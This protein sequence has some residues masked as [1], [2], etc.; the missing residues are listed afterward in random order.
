MRT[1]DF[2]YLDRN[3]GEIRERMDAARARAG[4]EDEV[5]LIVAAKSGT[6]EEL[7]Y[8]YEHGGVRDFGENRVQQLLE[9]YEQLPKGANIHFIGH[10]QTNKVKYIID[11]VTMIHSLDSER[12][13]AE[14]DKQAKKHGIVMKVL[15]EVNVGEE[16]NKS[17]VL[18]S[19]AEALCE[20]IGKFSNLSL[21]GLMTMAPVCEKKE[22]YL[23]FFEKISRLSVDI[24]SKKRDNK[25]RPI[26]SMGMSG[27][28]EEAIV[29]GATVVRV[30]RKLFEK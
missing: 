25:E 4:R 29:S 2:S 23:K 16:Q 24:W 8:L 9:H 6:A 26:L 17:G 19:E 30:G 21:C 11:K 20:A 3:L 13:A 22:D 7:N 5:G 14:I 10:L 1:V 27:S 15:V 12:L 18:P 28:F